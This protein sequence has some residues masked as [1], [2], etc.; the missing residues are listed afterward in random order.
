MK[1]LIVTADDFGR[2]TA[3]NEAVERGHREGI[4]TAASL[5]VTGAAFEDAV[6]RARR[7]PNLGVGLHVTLVDGVPV[8][9]PG[10]IPD[11]VNAEGRFTKK[12]NLLG[13][14]IFLAPWVRRQVEAELR[15]QFEAYRATGLRLDH[16]DSHHHYHLHPTVFRLL[17]PL[18]AEYGAKGVRIPIEPRWKPG[19]RGAAQRLSDALYGRLAQAMRA[20]AER[21]GLAVNDRMFGQSDSGRMTA[22]RLLA[23]LERVTDGLNEVYCHPA[24]RAAA[25]A[26]PMPGSYRSVDEF[27]ALV[28]TSVLERVRGLGIHLTTFSGGK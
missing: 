19:R 3:I 8:L 27:H 21:H 2:S 22:A 13:A 10:Q 26:H 7:L 25:D 15:A 16:V 1:H 9:P 18:A 12:P 14:K 6:F 4:L 23:V 11:L 5:M 24:S 28:D 20:L 17:I